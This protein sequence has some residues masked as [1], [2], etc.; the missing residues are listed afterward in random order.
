MANG[1]EKDKEKKQSN[2]LKTNTSRF[3]DMVHIILMRTLLKNS[4]LY[5]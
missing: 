1:V 4:T 3:M 2:C 5:S